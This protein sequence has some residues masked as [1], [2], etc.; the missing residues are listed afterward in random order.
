LLKDGGEDWSKIVNENPL[1]ESI[2][3]YVKSG[4]VEKDS[5]VKI[6]AAITDLFRAWCLKYNIKKRWLPI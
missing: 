3:F 4:Y 6:S 1:P 2:D 5:M